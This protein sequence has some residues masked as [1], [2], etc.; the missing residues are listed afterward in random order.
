MERIIPPYRVV[1]IILLLISLSILPT[2]CATLYWGDDSWTGKD[3]LYHFA[4]GGVIGAGMT[5]ALERNGMSRTNAP[6][7]GI[8][9]SVGIGAGKEW[10]DDEIRG[11]YWSMKDLVWDTIGGVAGSCL[12]K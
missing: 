7:L 5:I 8:T 12:F 10:Y 1:F 3:K 4:A 11:T 2:G 9:A 6:V